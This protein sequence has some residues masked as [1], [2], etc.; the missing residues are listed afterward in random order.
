MYFPISNTWIVKQTPF[1]ALLALWLQAFSFQWMMWLF[2]LAWMR[3]QR[4][5]PFL[6]QNR[7]FVS[8]V[9]CQTQS[10]FILVLHQDQLSTCQ[11]QWTDS[12]LGLL[13]STCSS[14]ARKKVLKLVRALSSNLMESA[15]KA[16]NEKTVKPSD[17]P[18]LKLCLTIFNSLKFFA[19]NKQLC[20]PLAPSATSSNLSSCPNTQLFQKHSNMNYPNWHIL[21]PFPFSI[22]KHTDTWPHM[23]L[24][25]HTSKQKKTWRE[26]PAFTQVQEGV[27]SHNSCSFPRQQW[28]H[29][30]GTCD[31]QLHWGRPPAHVLWH[32]SQCLAP[33]E[34]PS[35]NT[36]WAVLSTLQ[37]LTKI[38]VNYFSTAVWSVS[39]VSHSV[40]HSTRI[41]LNSSIHGAE[42]STHV[43]RGGL[44]SRWA[45][46]TKKNLISEYL[47]LFY[48]RFCPL[49]P[50]TVSKGNIFEEL[51][52][53]QPHQL[54]SFMSSSCKD[55][56][57]VS[58][59]DTCS[60]KGAQIYT[61]TAQQMQRCPE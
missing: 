17:L 46:L 49:K 13:L 53:Q 39:Y 54:N 23:Y 57:I 55:W 60:W 16:F 40:S 59:Q 11:Q 3:C 8:L 9:S 22:Y 21:H 45:E 44:H 14:S 18:R 48:D 24:D 6:Q 32:G 7:I 34:L 19:S 36:S 1:G 27:L 52:S 38:N 33:A 56:W 31:Y 61:C 20:N 4:K 42:L 29:A 2:D 12:T 28:V 30:L 35:I 5:A 15:A 43:P 51:L 25:T 41:R 37:K 26:V 50:G 58:M 47:H 10:S